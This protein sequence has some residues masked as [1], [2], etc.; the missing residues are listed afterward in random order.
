MSKIE[1]LINSKKVLADEG[2]S[3]LNASL[4]AGIYI[5]HLCYHPNLKPLGN[6]GLCVVN[7]GDDGEVVRACET[8]VSEGIKV[9]TNS[10]EV[11][12][13]RFT[14]LELML[15]S[16]PKDC[17]SCN[18]YL[19]CELQALLQY[20]GVA[21]ARLREIDKENTNLVKSDSLIK[22]EMFRC[23]QCGRCVRMCDDVRGVKALCINKKNGETYIST[24][25]DKPLMDTTCRACGACV[26]VCP[27]GAIQ[28]VVGVFPENVPPQLAYVP[29][30][31]DCPAHT[32]IPTYIRLTKDGE[33]NSAVEVLREKLT[34]PHSL[35]HICTHAC[36]G[37]CKRSHLNEPISIR[38]IKKFAVENDK[39]MTWKEKLGTFVSNKN[40]KKVAVIGGGASGMTSAF[41][42]ALKGYEVDLYEKQAKAGGM[43][44][45][46]IPKYRLSQ[47]IVDKEVEQ[48]CNYGIN[49]ITNSEIKSISDLDNKGYD[50]KLISIGAGAGKRPPNFAKSWTNATD[51]VIFCEKVNKDEIVNLEDD[52][53]VYGGGNVAFDAAINAK[54]LGAKN[55][56]VVCMEKREDMLADKEE[57]DLA[58]ELGV[59]INSGCMIQEINEDNN[60]VTSI[61]TIDINSFKF[62]PKGAEVDEV[63]GSEKNIVVEKIIF[64]TGQIP[65]LNE[66][67]GIELVKGAYTKTDDKMSTNIDGVFASGD[68]VYGTK[69]VVMAI[70]SGR[71]AASNIDLYLGGDGDM[72]LTLYNRPH[73]SGNIGVIDDFSNLKRVNEFTCSDDANSECSRCLQCDLRLDIEK[74]K[75]WVDSKYKGGTNE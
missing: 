67:F 75:Y 7:L 10:K 36:E 15:A 41:H 70:Q 63:V 28:D 34:F 11:E 74:V 66:S 45:Y 24:T 62:T 59:I 21:H 57:I 23:I 61:D 8:T 38:E 46:G 52:I 25:L 27:T 48:L 30:K 71:D 19:S 6:C 32:D 29:C 3:I 16:H 65:D 20:T 50:A 40:N 37:G 69:S 12:K 72:D 64:A 55:V 56:N 14:A 1:I 26:E 68:V 44:S 9:T 54:K 5:P 22:R 58:L 43:L 53:V 39:K 47:D 31:N 33:Y 18:K 17:S 13:I 51:A 4:D 60:K 2:Q 49:L 42:L 73:L 35:G